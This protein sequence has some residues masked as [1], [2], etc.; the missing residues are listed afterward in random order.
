MEMIS[1]LLKKGGVG[2]TLL[3]MGLAQVLAKRGKRVVVMD[4]G[5][6]GSAIGWSYNA[7]ENGRVLPY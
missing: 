2:K 1:L 3:S 5:P 4:H 6:E 7:N